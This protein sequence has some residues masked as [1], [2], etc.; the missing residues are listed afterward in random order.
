MMGNVNRLVFEA[1]SSNRYATFF[2]GQYEPVSRQ[3][4]YVNAGHNPPMLFHPYNEECQVSRLEA[5]GTVVGLLEDAL[6]QQ[7]SLAIAPGDVLIAFTDGI[8]EAMNAAEDEW[9]EQRLIDTVKACL[10]LPPA[11]IIACIMR[12]ADTFVAGAN[13]NDDMT[14]VV[15]RASSE[16]GN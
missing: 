9:G 1:S 12:T 14:L 7:A 6:Y 11:E 5:C 3:L 16:N 15:L 4:T 10:G 8:S 13:Q 2:Y